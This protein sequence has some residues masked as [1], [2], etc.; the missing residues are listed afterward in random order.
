MWSR[1]KAKLMSG[2]SV[3]DRLTNK[4]QLVGKIEIHSFQV[5]SLQRCHCHHRVQPV[6]PSMTEK[7]HVQRQPATQTAS[8][9]SI[10][11]CVLNGLRLMLFFF[12]LR[13]RT[14]IYSNVKF[15]RWLVLVGL[16]AI[17][18]CLQMTSQSWPVD[19]TQ[20]WV[21]WPLVRQCLRL[22]A[23]IGDLLRGKSCQLNEYRAV[24]RYN[25]CRPKDKVELNHNWKQKWIRCYHANTHTHTHTHTRLGVCF[26][27]RP[28]F[29]WSTDCGGAVVVII[30][31]FNVLRCQGDILRNKVEL[32]LLVESSLTS[33]SPKWY[34]Q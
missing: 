13:V 10:N 26:M 24:F 29:V 22:E 12:F 2:V 34:R 6:S 15:C 7:A 32:L 33:S 19:V 9:S 4:T 25:S 27:S 23:C 1:S 18:C 11:G 3:D 21:S 16:S 28:H 30:L 5:H 14:P 17:H 20:I 8:L 31:S